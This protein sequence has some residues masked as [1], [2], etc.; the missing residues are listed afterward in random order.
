MNNSRLF[1]AP[2]LRV[3]ACTI[4]ALLTA[5]LITS[6]ASLYI[7][8]NEIDRIGLP[9]LLFPITW[10]ILLIA[11]VLVMSIWRLWAIILTLV[12]I[13]GGLIFRHLVWGSL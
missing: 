4:G 5:T 9:I 13:H 2:I 1:S 3:L 11:S 7:P 6:G 10:I 12:L 8:L